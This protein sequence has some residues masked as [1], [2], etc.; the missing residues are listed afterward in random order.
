MKRV[1]LDYHCCGNR[2]VVRTP[3]REPYSLSIFQ[4]ITGIIS[5]YFGHDSTMAGH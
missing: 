2:K 3:W 1:N 4:D 5:G